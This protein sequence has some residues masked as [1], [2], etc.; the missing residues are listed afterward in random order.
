MAVMHAFIGDK[1]GARG[2]NSKS[3]VLDACFDVWMVCSAFHFLV[4]L[5]LRHGVLVARFSFLLFGVGS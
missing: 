5:D 1:P 4:A 2:P 3:V